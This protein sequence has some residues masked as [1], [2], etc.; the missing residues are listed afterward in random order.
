MGIAISAFQDR[1]SKTNIQPG[2][3]V[4]LLI[5]ALRRLRPE[6]HEFKASLDL[7]LYMSYVRVIKV[8][9]M[10]MKETAWHIHSR[11]LRAESAVKGRSQQISRENCDLINCIA[12][13]YCN[14][15]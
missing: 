13:Y 4:M 9:D 6:D 15:L 7:Y 5:P 8:K 14:I 3:M 1:T 10:L 12:F 11:G 2:V